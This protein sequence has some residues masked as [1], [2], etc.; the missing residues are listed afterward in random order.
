MEETFIDSNIQLPQNSFYDFYRLY[1]GQN[2]DSIN[3][4]DRVYFVFN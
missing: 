1:G 4:R 3:P 2:L